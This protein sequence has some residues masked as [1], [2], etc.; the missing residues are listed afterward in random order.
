MI[1]SILALVFIGASLL[2][3]FGHFV[4]YGL[5][6]CTEDDWYE[7]TQ[8]IRVAALFSGGVLTACSAARMKPTL[9][10]LGVMVGGIGWAVNMQG[11]ARNLDII[12]EC[13]AATVAQAMNKCGAMAD[14]YRINPVIDDEGRKRHMLTLV[15]PGTTDKAYNCLW[16][17]SLYGDVYGFKIDESVYV[18]ARSQAK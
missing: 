17:W 2:L 4:G 7:T 12:K 14:H 1:A 15:A 5:P 10:L 16:Q 6:P 9:L 8:T 18:H 13:K 11:E 3:V